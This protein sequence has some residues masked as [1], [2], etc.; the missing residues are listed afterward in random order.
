M[1]FSGVSGVGKTTVAKALC[2]E[3]GCDY[4]VV[5][6]SEDTGIDVLRTRVRS[7]AS[8]GSFSGKTK[9]V[10]YDEGDHLN[11][12]TTQPA[13][14]GFIE[15]FS[16]NCRFI[17]TCNYKNRLIT[18]IHSRAPVIEFKIERE[19]RPA[20]AARLMKRTKEILAIEGVEYDEKVVAQF[21]VKYF[22]D[23]RR[24]LLEL[25]NYSFAGK[26]DEGL[27]RI[28][29]DANLAPLIEALKEKSWKKMRTWVTNNADVDVK[30][31][32]RKLFDALEPL[33]KQIPEL[34]V[35]TN[36][37]QYKASFV[38]DAEINLVAYL[39][40]IM[41]VCTFKE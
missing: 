25:Q 7:F 40:E 12:L 26:I 5:A 32:F 6:G 41:A 1:I 39:T 36:D 21:L 13:L 17:F 28:G 19:D 11:P 9:V 24:I 30:T 31:L 20:M 4:I 27:L 3:L 2:E 34:V 33:I 14:R 18:H 23:Y 35:L 37:Y 22:P 16:K 38:A 8:T 15:E 10:I 29:A